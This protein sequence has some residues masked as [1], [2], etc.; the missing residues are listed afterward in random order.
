MMAL[1]KDTLLKVGIAASVALVVYLLYRSRSCSEQYAG[2]VPALAPDEYAENMYENAGDHADFA[3]AEYVP[4]DYAEEDADE[5][6]EDGAE[7]EDWDEAEDDADDDEDD[8]E[9]TG[10]RRGIQKMRILDGQLLMESTLEDDE[11]N[12]IFEPEL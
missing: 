5:E 9:D 2:Y 3:H 12:A 10:G 1:D 7:D 6:D 4:D 11:A 8:G